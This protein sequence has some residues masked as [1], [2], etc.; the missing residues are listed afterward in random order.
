MIREIQNLVK[1]I[2]R[3]RLIPTVITCMMLA[4]YGGYLYYLIGS[5]IGNRNVNITLLIITAISFIL[6]I[7]LHMRVVKSSTSREIKRLCRVAKTLTHIFA[8]GVAIYTSSAD[9]S[10]FSFL[11]LPV[12]FAQLAVEIIAAIIERRI[13]KKMNIKDIGLFLLDPLHIGQDVAMLIKKLSK[14]KNK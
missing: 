14:K 5:E 6:Q 13:A 8:L 4:L 3:I 9:A 12:W 7:L 10:I 1:L 2:K 11:M